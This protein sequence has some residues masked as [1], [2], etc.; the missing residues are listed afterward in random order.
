MAKVQNFEG[1]LGQTLKHS[2]ELCNSVQCH[3]LVNY[4]TFC[5][6]IHLCV[7]LDNFRTKSFKCITGLLND[8]RK[9]GRL[10]L[11]RTPCITFR[12]DIMLIIL[13]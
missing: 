8:V 13:K 6:S 2:L 7:P 12:A 3:T 5:L 11:S 1:I 10:V 9:E 4:F